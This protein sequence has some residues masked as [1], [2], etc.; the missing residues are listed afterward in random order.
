[1]SK[2]H[3]G[4]TQGDADGVGPEI[5]VKSL[6]KIFLQKVCKPVIFGDPHVFPRFPKKIDYEFVAVNSICSQLG[7]LSLSVLRCFEGKI[8]A[9]V[10]APVNKN[11]ISKELGTTFIGHTEYLAK[12]CEDRFHKK[13]HPTM[14]FI[15]KNERLALVTTHLP[16]SKVSTS[17]TRPLL[18]KTICNVYSALRSHFKILTPR[19]AI[20]GINPHAG[21]NGLIGNEENKIFKP[22]FLWAKK[23]N[24][25]IEGPFSADSFFATKAHLF[26]TTIAMYHD[27]GLAP[28]KLRNY[29]DAVNVTIGLPI[30]RTS[31]DHG[32]GYDI[33]RTNTANPQSMISAIHLAAKMSQC[34]TTRN[35][36]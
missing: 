15:G 20:L 13:F 1:M 23:Q 6:E 9:I 24:I 29:T 17:I 5:I 30:I 34:G 26:D 18:K 21:E 8:S 7:A 10:T 19:L 4:I 32:V 35:V 14:F 2:P 3:I 12:Q 22:I 16:L 33:V 11:K 36:L 27:Q 28:F 31:V 25:H